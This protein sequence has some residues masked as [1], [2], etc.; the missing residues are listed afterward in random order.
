[1]AQ[2]LILLDSV[3][4]A[5]GRHKAL[6]DVSGS[7]TAGSLTAI[8]GPNGAGKS[9]LLKAIAGVIKPQRGFVRLDPSIKGRIGYLTQTSAM[10]RHY[11]VNVGQVADA[12]LD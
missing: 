4:F 11:P 7:F 5:Y 12:P 8:A 3:C 9:T 2:P 1:M 6:H 10:K